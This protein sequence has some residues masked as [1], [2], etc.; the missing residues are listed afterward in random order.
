M[1][2]AGGD[3]PAGRGGGADP[4][5]SELYHAAL[6]R[7]PAERE[8]FLRQAC[9]GNDALQ[10]QVASL[11]EYADASTGFLQSP[12]AADLIGRSIGPYRVVSTLGQGGMGVVYRARDTKLGRDV[13]LKVLPLHWAADADRHARLD[14]EARALAT[15]NHPNIA[16]I[17][18]FEESG[19]VRALVLELV[20]GRAL[21]EI[22][23][24]GALP[25]TACL[26][27]AR[28][29]ADALAA[30][31]AK[32]IVHR[33]LKPGNI[34]WRDGEA[35]DPQIK[36]LDF[37]V[38]KL[39]EQETPPTAD[40]ALV[41]GRTG[42]SIIVGTPAYMSPEQAR[43]APVDK[44]TDV[45]AFG[46]VL[47][48][49][50]TGRPAFGRATVTDTLAAIVTGE[51]DWHALPV[52][53]PPAVTAMLRW[54]LQ[55]DVS[56]RLHDIAGAR[57]ALAPA[58]ET[59]VGVVTKPRR[60]TVLMAGIVVLVAA[61]AA[62]GWWVWPTA[63]ILTSRDTIVLA[64]F[65][66][67]TG[68][69]AFDGTMRHALATAL[70]QSPFL[71]ILPDERV[72]EVLRLMDRQTEERVTRTIAREICQRENLKA[73]VAGS[74]SQ[75]GTRYVVALE[76]ANGQTGDVLAREQAEAD[77]KEGVLSALSQVAARLREH[78]GESLTS[79][80]SSDQPIE[81]V[82]T[83]SLD[84]YHSYVLGIDHQ[85]KLSNDEAVAAL[86]RAI[87]LDPDFASAHFALANTYGNMGRA[88]AGAEST[89]RAFDLRHRATERER[90][91]IEAGYLGRIT[92][93]LDAA[94]IALE[95]LR[96]LA[97]ND[98]RPHTNLS[99]YYRNLGEFKESVAAA[100]ESMRLRPN[101]GTGVGNLIQSLERLNQ[102]DEA[103]TV[104]T[105]A[106][107]RALGEGLAFRGTLFRLGVA[108]GDKRLADDQL[109]WAKGTPAQ[110]QAAGW[111]AN[112]VAATGRLRRAAD[113]RRRAMALAQG[114]GE[115][116][117]GSRAAQAA[118]LAVTGQCDQARAEA[119]EARGSSVASTITAMGFALGYCGDGTAASAAAEHLLE[120]YPRGTLEKNLYVPLVRAAA[121][122]PKNPAEVLTRLELPRSFD[123]VSDFRSQYLRGQAF[124]RLSRAADAS[125]EFQYILDHR[126][127]DVLSVLYPLAYVGLAR[128][129]VM[130]GDT[131]KAR[132]AYRQ[133]LDL[134]KDAEPDLPILREAGQ[135]LARL[136]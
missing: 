13:A 15:L 85:R 76:A 74:I 27:A 5:V 120:L 118:A 122:F 68:D 114:A 3:G 87:E 82:T 130:A 48:E 65:A 47:F 113:L 133:F 119:S 124:L 17:Y 32:G 94:V 25:L 6:D 86:T 35:L 80:R 72:R 49:M 99:A 98:S 116:P 136:K 22:L 57:P 112:A 52:D 77:Q 41:A 11:L 44:R 23:A 37:G 61:L 105:D 88:R 12:P 70:E 66:N 63:P 100:R 107:R 129:A 81:R 89:K 78:L 42:T 51:P 50:L 110:R 46:C 24:R 60:R 33:D 95:Q 30:A 1:A 38:A 28:Q 34:V 14:R 102:F 106:V 93:E 31:H 135:E 92:R 10:S 79:V 20:E 91:A 111:E 69:A 75:L 67:T 108:T 19:N 55:K 64:E 45:W 7:L 4:R 90:L 71:K 101:S 96:Q 2:V 26:A 134:W 43:G 62:A 56:A 40:T 126:G 84:A 125:A 16:T 117:A 39:A 59:R 132:V 54:C 18:G 58:A 127:E 109:A 36:L 29:I 53:T 103:R 104:A 73:L 121:A 9:G 21:S 115:D 83:S 128:A 131:E 8:A 123:R 97:P